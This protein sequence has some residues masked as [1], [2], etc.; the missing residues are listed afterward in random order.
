MYRKKSLGGMGFALAAGLAIAA[1]GAGSHPARADGRGC[2]AW[3]VINTPK[4]KLPAGG[5]CL[6]V[7]GSGLKIYYMDANWFAPQLCNWRIDWVIY[8]NGKA[9]W[10][11]KGPVHGCNNAHG[12]RIRTAGSAPDHSDLCAELYEA[13]QGIKIDAACVSIYR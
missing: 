12:N 13:A 2:S 4:G 10:R 1:A 11:D 8:S 9:W 3:G 6:Q 5:I 7:F